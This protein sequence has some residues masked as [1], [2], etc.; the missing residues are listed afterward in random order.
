MNKMLLWFTQTREARSD[1]KSVQI[2][3]G[4]EGHARSRTGDDDDDEHF[5]FSETRFCSGGSGQ[6]LYE[7]SCF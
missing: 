1:G 6:R 4:L 2:Q 5:R 7:F 3:Y